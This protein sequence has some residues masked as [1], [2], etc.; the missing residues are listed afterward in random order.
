MPGFL[1]ILQPKGKRLMVSDPLTSAM[2]KYLLLTALLKG[3][4]NLK[5]YCEVTGMAFKDKEK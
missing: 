2:Q 5:S 1:A 4:K 3:I